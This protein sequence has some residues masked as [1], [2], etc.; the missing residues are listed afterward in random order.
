MA[1]G[2]KVNDTIQKPF[3]FSELDAKIK[4]I[5]AWPKQTFQPKQFTI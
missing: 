2:F 4:K 1:K 5:F 3:A